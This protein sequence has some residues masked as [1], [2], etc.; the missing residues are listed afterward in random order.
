MTKKQDNDNEFDF[1]KD[2][3]D[4]QIVIEKKRGYARVNQ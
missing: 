4:M 1:L 2:C 3:V